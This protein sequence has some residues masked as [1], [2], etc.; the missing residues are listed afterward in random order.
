MTKDKYTIRGF[1][2]VVT[3]RAREGLCDVMLQKNIR[4][5]DFPLRGKPNQN[6]DLER[7]RKN[8]DKIKGGER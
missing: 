7:H 6:F 2:R 8:P 5:E 1:G 4:C 3:E